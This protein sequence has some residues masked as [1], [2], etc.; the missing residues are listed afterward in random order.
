MCCQCP[1]CQ[2]CLTEAK[3][4]VTSGTFPR[5]FPPEGSGSTI[6]AEHFSSVEYLQYFY[7][8]LTTHAGVLK[9]TAKHNLDSWLQQS[10]IFFFT[11]GVVGKSFVSDKHRAAAHGVESTTSVRWLKRPP[12]GCE[13]SNV[14]IISIKG[15]VQTFAAPLRSLFVFPPFTHV[16]F[17]S[18]LFSASYDLIDCCFSSGVSGRWRGL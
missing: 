6:S 17:S 5:V 7:L 2:S 13:V 18:C 15:T 10:T 9:V 3:G 12:A 1:H 8:I 14:S 11:C 4:S 16:L